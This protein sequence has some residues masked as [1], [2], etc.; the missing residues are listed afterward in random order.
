MRALAAIAA[1]SLSLAAPARIPSWVN[2]Q[3]VLFANGLGETSPRVVRVR[4]NVRE[5]GH[6]VDHIWLRGDFTCRIC[7][8]NHHT[9]A[10]L[11]LDV[12]THGI[13]A[14]RIYD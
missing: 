10:Q 8:P 12:R 6:L 14:E 11:I 13:I 9:H 4:L 1:V 2:G 5:H 7:I 3:I